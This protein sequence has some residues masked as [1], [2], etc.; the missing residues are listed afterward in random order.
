[1][2]VNINGTEF[3][4]DVDDGSYTVENVTNKAGYFVVNATYRSGNTRTLFAAGTRAVTPGE[5]SQVVLVSDNDYFIVNKIAT[6]TTVEII[7]AIIGNV[8]INV[9]VT[10][11]SG[12]K[13]V[14]GSVRVSYENGTVIFGSIDLTN[15]EVDIAIP[16]NTAGEHRLIVSYLE[17]DLYLPSN[18]TNESAIGTPT[19]EV[20]IIDVTKIPTNTSVEILDATIGNVTLN[21]TVTNNTG[22]AV[23]TGEVIVTNTTGRV[24]AGGEL[25]DGQLIV[26]IP[27]E[28]AGRLEVIVT[29]PENDIYYS[30][31]A[32]NNTEGTADNIIVIDVTKI[33]TKTNLTIINNTI[34]NVMV[35]V[36]V[37]NLTGQLVTTGHVEVYDN[38]TG[39]LIG[40]AE[41]EDGEADITL[42]VPEPG[43]IYINATYLE[44]DIYY[45]SNATDSSKT[46]GSPDENTTEIDVVKQN[47]TIIIHIV[48]DN[49]TIGETVVI[50]GVVT[51]QM[52]KII[53][54]GTV[55]ININQ[56]EFT[57]E[58]IDGE[59][60][61]DNITDKVGIFDVNATFTGNV[62]VTGKTSQTLQFTVNKIPTI[63]K[64]EILNH[65]VGNVTIEVTVTND[66]NSPVNM[67]YVVV[68]NAT[69]S[70]IV[71]STITD[72]KAVL[73]I[74]SSDVGTIRVNVSYIENDYYLPSNAR[75]ASLIEGDPDEN[76]TVIDVTKASATI[77]ISINATNVTIGESVNVSGAVRDEYGNIIAENVTVVIDGIEYPATFLENGTYTV[78]NVTTK[79]GVFT[80][81]ATYTGSESVEGVTSESLNFTVNKIPTDTVVEVLNNTVG[82]VTVEVTVTDNDANPITTG[83]LN[84]TVDGK[85]TQ[86]EVSS[87]TTQ[88]KLDINDVGDIA[89][90][91]E[92]QE[93]DRY[94]NSTGINKDTIPSGGQP[95]DGEVLENITTTKQVAAIT[96]AAQPSN[97][98][99][100]QTVTITGNLTV[101]DEAIAD[102]YVEVSVD[103]TTTIVKTGADGSYTLEN[104]T[105]HNGTVDV[106]VYY[107]G[108][109][110]V[111]NATANTSF[112]VD[113][114]PTITLVEV[115]NSTVGNVSID[116]IV[117]D[118]KNNTVTSG[119]I[120]ITTPSKD[121]TVNVTGEVTHV[122][123]DITTTGDIP[124]TVEYA[125]NDVY[126][127][128]SGLDKASYDAD[129]EN[130]EPFTNITVN[131]HN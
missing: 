93:N 115:T 55:V 22:E 65:T 32:K 46:P 34:G 27:A 28:S 3:T 96:V 25:T 112:D 37:T 100:G 75:N 129:P 18:A 66:T 92:Y 89:V 36:N 35:H 108:N 54:D 103:G 124:V 72:G 17:N 97:T 122:S 19:E 48:D 109:S 82:N 130:P 41:L 20:I 88:I 14:N 101:Y 73:T 127:N 94:L 91:V 68:D 69:T 70:N 51:D 10:N 52:G 47:A 67:G 2:T 80:V 77:S 4:V 31:H 9:N 83:M 23:L 79:A 119:Q 11:N 107:A 53:P 90:K 113:K 71:N 12:D 49:V 43:M 1:V 123:L 33:P 42:D 126:L 56:T 128:S 58:I 26:E 99:I 62:N 24:L 81:N 118:D 104:V 7:N 21:I 131:K 116:V 13:V 110:T 6:N 5:D 76:V 121:I 50:Y 63:T 114:I 40:E 120:K 64:V 74:P 59:Y 84:V 106:K 45:G 117:K 98:T 61:L 95:E 78:T 15:G 8:T 57:T 39:S 44:N 111:S 30:S 60:R 105:N 85:T 86:V 102:A 16:I 87:P 29:Y 125:E 38:A